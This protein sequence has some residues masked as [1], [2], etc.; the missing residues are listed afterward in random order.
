MRFGDIVNKAKG[1][2]QKSPEKARQAIDRVEDTID[3]KTGGKYGDQI[4]KGGDAVEQKLGVAQAAKEAAQSP[5]AGTGSAP[6]EGTGDS[7]QQGSGAAPDP[8]QA[9]GAPEQTGNAPQEGT[10]DTPKQ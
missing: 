10:E 7:S 3:Q 4:R 1:L 6:Q 8:K 9:G 2:A 5:E